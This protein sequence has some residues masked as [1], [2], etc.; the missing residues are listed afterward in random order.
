[1]KLLKAGPSP[2]VRKVL[3][4]LHETDQYDAVEQVQVTASPL[5]PDPN[6]IAANPV[7]KIPALIRDDG[8]TLYDSRVICRFLDHRAQTG[9]YPEVRQFDTLT[10]EA[11]ADGI[12]DAAVLIV[13]EERFRPADK[14]SMEW[15]EGQWAKVS[16]AL[17]AVSTRWMSHLHG[18]IDIG[19]IGMA[20]ALSYLDFRH[21]ARKWRTGRDALAEWHAGFAARPSMIATEPDT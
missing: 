16:R 21:D 11:T 15:I 10:L 19:H 12:M 14:V 9:L 18:R 1:M 20:C 2:F 8:P 4:T 3:V 5:T 7:G 17:D 13:Y 6:L